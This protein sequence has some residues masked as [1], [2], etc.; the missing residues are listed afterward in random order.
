VVAAWLALGADNLRLVAREREARSALGPVVTQGWRPSLT[1][2]ALVLGGVLVGAAALER[3][4]GRFAFLPGPVLVGL[5]LLAAGVLL[6]LRARRALGPFWSG[7]IELRAGHALVEKGPYAHVRHPIYL[8]V[9]LVGV[10]SLLAHASVAAACAAGGLV[11]GL[12]LKLRTEERLLVAS[13]GTEYERYA[14]RVP[15]LV[16]ALRPV[17]EALG[18][19][20]DTRRRRYALLLGILLWGGWLASIAAGPGFLDLAGEVKGADFIEFYAAGKLVATGRVAELYDLEAQRR[21]EHAVTSPQDWPGLHA[22]LNPPFFAL[23]FVPLAH[24]PYGWAFALWSGLGIVLL[25]ASAWLVARTEA[26]WEGRWRATMP[27][28]LAFVPVFAAVSYGQNSLLSLWLLTLTF[29]AL[30]RGRDLGAGLVLGCLLY[31]P[32][33]VFVLAIAL[34][35][36]RRWRVLAGIALT[37]SCLVAASLAMSVPATRSY[38]DLVRHFPTMLTHPGFPTWNMHSLYSFFFLLL[39]GRATLAQALAVAA[40]ALTLWAMRAVQPAYAP[41]TLA[42]WYAAAL[43]A[44]V[45][46]SPHVF[47]Y[48]LS[49]LALAGLL[50][51]PERRDDAA[52]IGGVGLVWAVLVFS[53]PLARALAAAGASVQLSVPVLAAVG[54]S[55][56]APRRAP[57]AYRQAAIS[58]LQMASSGPG[59]TGV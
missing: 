31:K 13:L 1:V 4:T 52:W 48:D 32:Q 40:A 37:G 47:L 56:L 22:F 43:W 24:L 15:A 20:I 51:W 10:G 58:R 41:D 33:L 16:P 45:L 21:V 7:V 6:H 54:Y 38:V 44:T 29:A 49:V 28:L 35:V 25:G 23:P 17:L 55:L 18:T 53:G 46:V 11:V 34:L 30:R 19:W 9:L 57:A 26:A 42:R 50:L 3:L 27:W 12:V 39:P 2:R 5:L 8:A 14:A 59:R 36:E